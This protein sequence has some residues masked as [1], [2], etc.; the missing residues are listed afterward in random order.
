MYPSLVIFANIILSNFG[1]NEL[2]KLEA[3]MHILPCYIGEFKYLISRYSIIAEQ[4]KFT[5]GLKRCVSI[6]GNFCKYYSL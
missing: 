6:T 5:C 2:L 3:L 4:Q 1:R